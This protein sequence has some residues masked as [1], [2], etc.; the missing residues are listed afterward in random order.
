MMCI[1]FSHPVLVPIVLV[2]NKTDLLD[3]EA[4]HHLAESNQEF[5]MME[6]SYELLRM[7][8]SYAMAERI[9]AYAYLKC[10]AKL[11][12]GVREVFETAGKAAF[13]R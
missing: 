13:Q 4:I 2:A 12:E 9:G 7:E 1:V 10:S 11:N 3:T 8:E 6:D 5:L